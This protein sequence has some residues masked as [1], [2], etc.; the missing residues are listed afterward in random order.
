MSE[1]ESGIRRI[2]LA[3]SGTGDEL[4]AID[5]AAELAA[6]L[7]AEL[8]ALFVED[9]DLL[10]ASRLPSMWEMGRHSARLRLMQ[11]DSTMRLL[12][13]A[14]RRAEQAL[15]RAAMARS[16]RYS[17]RILQGKPLPTLL[18]EAA[19]LD[20]VLLGRRAMAITAHRRP[21]A[22]LFDGSMS[23]AGTLA[24]GLKLARATDRPCVVLVVAADAQ[25][26]RALAQQVGW[27][28]GGGAEV[29]MQRLQDDDPA[30]LATAVNGL[31]AAALA[32]PADY[33]EGD[34]NRLGA[35]QSRL[36][37]DLLLVT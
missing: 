25:T 5:A 23:A 19:S 28:V 22:V 11:A 33:T 34:L 14:A 24:V 37:C 20:L 36:R 12:K 1:P 10:R 3:L 29:S 21:L 18:T 7:E 13:A 35:L 2:L 8:S 9:V 27:A 16:L 30:D 26:Y 6:A 4:A 31:R 32:L 15:Q 17:F